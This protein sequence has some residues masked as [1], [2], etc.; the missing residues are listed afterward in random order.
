[1]ILLLTFCGALHW[2]CAYTAP[3]TKHMLGEVKL[4]NILSAVCSANDKSWYFYCLN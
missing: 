4:R 1:M 3:H 2:F